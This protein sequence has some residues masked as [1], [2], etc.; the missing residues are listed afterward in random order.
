MP[1]FLLQALLL[2]FASGRGGSASRLRQ[3]NWQ[4]DCPLCVAEEHCHEACAQVRSTSA[5]S[6]YCLDACTGARPGDVFEEAYFKA[7]DEKARAAA[8]LDRHIR[9]LGQEL[10]ADVEAAHAERLG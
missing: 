1:S 6:R 2:L 10:A 8:E 4:W 3:Q 9:Q 5:G 7:A